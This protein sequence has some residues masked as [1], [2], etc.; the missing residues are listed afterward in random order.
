MLTPTLKN[1]EDLL[2]KLA[3]EQ[4]R[5]LHSRSHLHKADHLYNFCTTSLAVR[6]FMFLTLAYDKDKKKKFNDS[7][8]QNAELAA[9]WGK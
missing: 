9:F 2:K 5:V 1:P 6:D 4:Y 7:W 3:R 8:Y